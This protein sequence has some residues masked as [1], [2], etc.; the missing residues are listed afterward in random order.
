MYAMSLP[1]GKKTIGFG[2][3][4][5]DPS[6]RKRLPLEVVSGARQLSRDEAMPIFNDLVDNATR[7][8]KVYLGEDVF[9]AMSPVRQ[10]AFV[11]M[12]FN[13]GL[14][15]LLRFEETQK[16]AVSGDFNRAAIEILNSKYAEQVKDRARRISEAVRKGD[17]DGE[18]R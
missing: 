15:R 11:N 9:N 13:L 17:Q 18:K 8:A 12:A 14:P 6:V 16:A 7:D 1:E 2:F 5:D 4:I 3:N 10:A